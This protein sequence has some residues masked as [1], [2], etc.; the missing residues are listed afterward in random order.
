MSFPLKRT[1]VSCYVQCMRGGSHPAMLLPSNRTASFAGGLYVDA[2]CVSLEFTV[3]YSRHRPGTRSSLVIHLSL[4][5]R[6]RQVHVVLKDK[7][8]WIVTYHCA[9]TSHRNTA[10]TVTWFQP[11]HGIFFPA[12]CCFSVRLLNVFGKPFF[13]KYLMF[14][15]G[16]VHQMF[17]VEVCLL[18]NPHRVCD[19]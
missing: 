16:E 10:P 17:E 11:S 13:G 19:W 5:S 14:T 7:Q 9:I 15:F 12:F 4:G 6:P 2:F 3:L 18:G 8:A 1:C